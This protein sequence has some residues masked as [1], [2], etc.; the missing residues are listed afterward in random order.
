MQILEKKRGKGRWLCGAAGVEYHSS[1]QK[2]FLKPS[3][4]KMAI[5]SFLLQIP[6]TMVVINDII[7]IAECE[8]GG[9]YE[10]HYN[11]GY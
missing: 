1:D 10:I 3:T 6:Q 5:I 11:Q 2:I 7:L 9:Y 4:A 8:S